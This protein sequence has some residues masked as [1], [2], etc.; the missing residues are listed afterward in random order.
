MIYLE[1]IEWLNNFGKILKII[2]FCILNGWVVYVDE[3]YFNK[4]FIESNE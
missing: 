4:V 1:K 3:L 2:T